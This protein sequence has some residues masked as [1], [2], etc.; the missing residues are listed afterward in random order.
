VVL[1]SALGSG[2]AGASRSVAQ[3][4][5]QTLRAQGLAK[6]DARAVVSSFSHCF[7]ARAHASDPTATP[8]GCVNYAALTPSPIERAVHTAAT[9]AVRRNF[10]GAFEVATVFNVVTVAL[11]LALGFVLPARRRRTNVSPAPSTSS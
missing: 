10:T 3:P 2:A 1:F 8:R 5:T 11:T 6:A 9:A 4:L 7:A